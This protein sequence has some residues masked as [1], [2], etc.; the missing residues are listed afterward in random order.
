MTERMV[1]GMDLNKKY[2]TSDGIECNILQMVTMEPEWAANR[3][4]ATEPS[5]CTWTEDSNGLYN[6]ECG[7]IF[8]C[9]EGDPSENGFIY[10]PYCGDE[11]EVAK[12]N[13]ED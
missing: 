8:E 1:G 3:I 6:T 9:M 12:Y 11:I 13:L 5:A 2:Y 7:H 4:Q 10:C